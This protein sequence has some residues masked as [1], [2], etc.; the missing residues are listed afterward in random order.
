M[1]LHAD[2]MVFAVAPR[3]NHRFCAW[4]QGD[5]GLLWYPSKYPSYGICAT[6]QRA[7]F[8]DYYLSNDTIRT[9]TAG[10]KERVIGMDAA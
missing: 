6:C 7:Y 8:P 2:R 1:S 10:L 3:R 4:C 5:L 9:S